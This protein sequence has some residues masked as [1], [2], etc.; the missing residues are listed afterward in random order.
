MHTLGPLRWTCADVKNSSKDSSSNISGKGE[1]RVLICCCFVTKVTATTIGSST[2]SIAYCIWS[3]STTGLFLRDSHPIAL[4]GAF[5]LPFKMIDL[6]K[7]QNWGKHFPYR[8]VSLTFT[9]VEEADIVSQQCGNGILE[10]Q[11]CQMKVRA[12][13][14]GFLPVFVSL[15]CSSDIEYPW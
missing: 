8:S 6:K 5:L 1:K 11:E 12:W 2:R 15:Y 9:V 7:I 13:S 14:T 4:T 3:F 10:Q